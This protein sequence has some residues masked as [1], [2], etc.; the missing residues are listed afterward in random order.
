LK[1]PG[2]IYRRP[3]LLS[4]LCILTFLGSTIGF[5]GY[6]IASLFF[7]EISEIIIR[8]SSWHTTSDISAVYFLILMVFYSISLMGAIRMWKLH[9]N[10]YFLYVPAQLVILLLPVIWINLQ[11]LSVTNTFFTIVFIAGYT[12]NMKFLKQ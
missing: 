9:R 6:F 12:L 5:I 4:A 7:D 2:N 8:Y 3:A 11:A 1:Q 10:G